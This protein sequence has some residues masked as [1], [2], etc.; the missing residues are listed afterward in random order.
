M[1]LS[2]SIKLPPKAE[3]KYPRVPTD[4]NGEG[5]YAELL[6]K[7][8][9]IASSR[10]DKDRPLLLITFDT[11]CPWCHR[12]K[13][14]YP[15]VTV[16]WYPVATL[17]IHSEPQGSA[18]LASPNPWDA[19]CK[20]MDEFRA[21]IKP[22]GRTLTAKEIEALPLRLREG[23]WMNSKIHRRAVCRTVPFGVFRTGTG[24]Y[25]PVYS[26]MKTADLASLMGISGVLKK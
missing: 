20:H 14:L 4:W 12:L 15:R 13:P 18:M 2:R 8:M 21:D 22:R 25:V 5:L 3:H 26:R 10:H 6:E 17:S 24:N 1:S 11:Q 9:G 7:G 19:F 16:V 23:I